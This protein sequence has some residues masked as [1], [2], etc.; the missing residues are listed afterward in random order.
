MPYVFF[1]YRPNDD[2]FYIIITIQKN[3]L[4]LNSFLCIWS[5]VVVTNIFLDYCQHVASSLKSMQN[6]LY[7][8][9]MPKCS[10]RQDKEVQIAQ[11]TPSNH[12][13]DARGDAEL[14]NQ[15]AQ[16]SK[17]HFRRSMR[18]LDSCCKPYHQVCEGKDPLSP[19]SLRWATV[20]K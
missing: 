6:C 1:K 19:V 9:K 20:M 16:Y 4:S 12:Q 11:G 17:T 2:C 3:Q 8:I 5:C 15:V 13:K 14:A 7:S 18:V 10:T